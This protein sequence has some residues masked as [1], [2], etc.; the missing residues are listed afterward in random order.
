MNSF[1]ISIESELPTTS[2]WSPAVTEDAGFLESRE[3]GNI[4]S[5]YLKERELALE[6]FK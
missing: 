6:K 2:D 3:E 1:T 4:H 5:I